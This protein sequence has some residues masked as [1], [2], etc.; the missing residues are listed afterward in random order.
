MKIT[1]VCGHFIPAMG[2]IEVHL[3]RALSALKCDVTVVTSTAIPHY[4]KHL[5]STVGKAPDGVKVIRLKPFF[6]LGQIVAARG[7]KM[8]VE[9]SNPDKVIV[10]G[11]G[12]RYP[13]PVYDLNI[14]ITTLFGD[15]ASSYG[16]SPG[17]KTKILFDVFKRST[18]ETA[19]RKSEKLV[20]YTPESFEAAAKMLG[21]KFENIL[22]GSEHFIS[23]G[24]HPDEFFFSDAIR[25]EKRRELGLAETDRVVITATRIRPE[26]NLEAAI[27][28]FQK[29][30]EHQ[31]WILVGSG[32]DGY[33]QKLRAK[34][35]SDLGDHRF[36]ILPHVERRELNAFYN[37]ADAALYTAPAISIVEAMGTGLPVAIPD[38]KS[39][40]H[41]IKN[42]EQ[43]VYFPS[44][45][46]FPNGDFITNPKNRLKRAEQAVEQ[47]SWESQ[48]LKLLRI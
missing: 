43:G 15:N 18:Y 6:T 29:S 14:P 13:K 20:A 27:P 40:S 22:R 30:S 28:Y 16:N 42:S 38:D 48:A 1:L 45:R 39:L 5:H 37:A 12:K 21:G 10:I 9:E 24:F 26:K 2:Y 7:V 25:S 8:A 17:L 31:K 44:Q 33:A 11:L 3:A 32:E 46:G 4:V 41:L 47:L 19:I 23:L 35:A 34:L 36:A